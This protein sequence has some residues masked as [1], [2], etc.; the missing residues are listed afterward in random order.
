[1]A[2]TNHIAHI[3]ESY[4]KMGF[5][6][7]IDDFGAGY[8]GLGLLAKF[9][10]DYI[11]LDMELIRAIDTSMPRRLIVESVI[12]MC[13]KFGIVVIAEGV[14]TVAE[15]H[16]LRK[17]GIRYIQGY[18]LA[19]PALRGLPTISLPSAQDAPAARHKRR[20]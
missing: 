16:T 17:L 18:L 4:R 15:Y 12:R 5:G 20:V 1:M 9:Q 11:N 2:D 7:A 10:P 8:A 19:R 6:T 14:E 13:N 3:V